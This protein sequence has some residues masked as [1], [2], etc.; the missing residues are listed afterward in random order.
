MKITR[1]FIN[2]EGERTGDVGLL[3][4]WIPKS[5]NFDPTYGVRG[6]MHDCIEHRLCDTGK[7]HEEAMAFGRLLALRVVPGNGDAN[8]RSLGTEFAGIIGDSMWTSTWDQILP[9]PPGVGRLFDWDARAEISA[10]VASCQ[11]A[12]VRDL[13]DNEDMDRPEPEFYTRLA[14][15]L[16]IGFI[17]AHRRYGGY[18]GCTEVGATF[19]WANSR[20]AENSLRSVTANLEEGDC[21]RVV[22]DTDTSSATFTPLHMNY[23]TGDHPLWL[24]RRVQAWRRS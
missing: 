18:R 12:L 11:H 4:L 6:M 21:V 24:R 17:D 2:A 23:D 3:P 8:S 13:R 5:A 22:V 14:H 20:E 19:D 9:H 16:M 15:W 7:P 10:L 1:Y